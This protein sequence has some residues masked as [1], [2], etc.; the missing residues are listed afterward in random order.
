MTLEI[1]SRHFSP[2][3]ALRELVVTKASKIEKFSN[4]ITSCHIVLI[5]ENDIESVEIKA[6]MKGHEMFAHESANMFEKSLASS[7]EKIVSQIKKNRDKDLGKVKT[8]L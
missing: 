6:H 3:S 4:D 7:V 2:S 1:T 5:K 8:H